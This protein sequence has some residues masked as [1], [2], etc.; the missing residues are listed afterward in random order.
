MP[1]L[2]DFNYGDFV[3]HGE[4]NSV[5]G[6]LSAHVEPAWEDIEA[7]LRQPGL[8][9][10]SPIRSDIDRLH[11]VIAA[12]A[13]AIGGQRLVPFAVCPSCGSRSVVFGDSKPLGIRGIPRVTFDEYKRLPDAMKS[14]R[15]RELWQQFG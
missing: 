9:G 12:L 14:Q 2:G 15:L 11:R 4:R 5:F 1:L 6:F 8:L 10:T 13:D 7:R 3:L